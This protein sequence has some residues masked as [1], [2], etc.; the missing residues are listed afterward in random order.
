MIV[1]VVRPQ[2]LSERL[3]PLGQQRDL[4][5]GR[6]GIALMG[7]VV[8]HDRA[9]G[10]LRERHTFLHIHSRNLGKGSTTR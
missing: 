2:M 5:F 10:V 7:C 3:D 6:A 4:N 9:L 1:V 8:G